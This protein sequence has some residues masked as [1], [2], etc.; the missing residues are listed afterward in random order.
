MI[1]IIG[2]EIRNIPYGVPIEIALVGVEN[3]PGIID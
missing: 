2:T 3:Q 1:N